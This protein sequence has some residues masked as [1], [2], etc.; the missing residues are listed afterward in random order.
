LG[1]RR[2]LAIGYG[3]LSVGFTQIGRYAEAEH[4]IERSLA[5]EREDGMERTLTYALALARLGAIRRH[6]L[7]LSE[8][9]QT[10]TEALTLGIELGDEWIISHSQSML[11]QIAFESGDAE[12]AKERGQEALATARR[13][14]SRRDELYTLCSI[15]L[16]HLDLGELDQAATAAASALRLARGREDLI[17][18]TS[19]QFLAEVGCRRGFP[20]RAARL[21]GY[22]DEWVRRNDFHRRPSEQKRYDK[23]VAALRERLS[24]REIAVLAAEGARYGDERAMDEALALQ[25]LRGGTPLRRAELG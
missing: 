15:A 6:H 16:V 19:L 22:M 4:A 7:R 23:A 12:T 11:A 14:G 20:E 5:I 17:A 10:V 8:A 9:E 25:D 21:I 24:D 18:I 1:D 3:N 13:I 2:G